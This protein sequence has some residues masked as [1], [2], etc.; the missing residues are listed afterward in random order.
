MEVSGK[1]I[2]LGATEE[3]GASAFKKRLV[4]I[5]TAEQYPQKVPVEFVKDN[6]S[7]LDKYKV[8]DGVK[9]AINIRGNEYKG[10]YYVSLQGWKIEGDSEKQK[11]VAPSHGVSDSESDDLP[12]N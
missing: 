12:F 2:V 3:I 4:V 8:G 9:I 10:K 11:T 5:E 7:K 1:I 6:T